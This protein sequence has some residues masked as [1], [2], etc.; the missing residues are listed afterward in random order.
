MIAKPYRSSLRRADIREDHLATVLRERA[1]RDCVVYPWEPAPEPEERR[2]LFSRLHRR[3]PALDV[4]GPFV[5]GALCASWLIYI[6][7]RMCATQVG[8]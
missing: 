8:P 3:W 2:S 1:A 7:Y 6:V 5:G 4:I